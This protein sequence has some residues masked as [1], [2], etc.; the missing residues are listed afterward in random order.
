MKRVHRLYVDVGEEIGEKVMGKHQ[1]FHSFFKLTFQWIIFFP[2][3]FFCSS[4]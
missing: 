4:Y 3:E 1:M 2:L